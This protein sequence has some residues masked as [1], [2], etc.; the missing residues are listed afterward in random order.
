M[1]E[2]SLDDALAAGEPVMLTIAT[3]GF[4]ETAICGPTVEVVEAV[5]TA[6]PA[7]GSVRWIHL[8]V[9]SDA[10]TTVADPVAAWQLQSEPWIFGIGSDGTIVGRLDG[11]LTVLDGEVAA[12]AAQ[13]A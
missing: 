8:E 1:H 11:P 10:G 2:V 6:E 9:F 4:C 13:L 5:R 3:P 12:L 7:G